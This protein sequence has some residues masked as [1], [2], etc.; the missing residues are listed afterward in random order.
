MRKTKKQITEEKRNYIARLSL[1]LSSDYRSEVEKVRYYEEDH[2]EYAKITFRG[3]HTVIIDITA[4]SCGG[5][6]KDVGTA[7]YGK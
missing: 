5:I 4:D 7:V 1:L 2:N 3:G 6:Y